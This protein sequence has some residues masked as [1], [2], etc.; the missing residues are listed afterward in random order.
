M[1]N[2]LY[3]KTLKLDERMEL[4]KLRNENVN[5]KSSIVK[6]NK[7]I[8]TLENKLIDNGLAVRKPKN[9]IKVQKN[10]SKTYDLER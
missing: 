9:E 4:H 10:K 6:Q 8:T 1:E 7:Y 2:Q 3:E 5:L